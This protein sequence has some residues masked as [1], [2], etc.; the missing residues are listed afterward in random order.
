MADV[1]S[2]PTPPVITS[3]T[4]VQYGNRRSQR[5]SNAPIWMKDYAVVVQNIPSTS[6]P[7]YSTDHY[8]GYDR[9]TP[10]Y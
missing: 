1:I 7:L 3:P 10:P 5:T 2:S 8:L 9:L 4:L 6:K